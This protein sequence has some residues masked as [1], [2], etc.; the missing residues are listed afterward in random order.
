MTSRRAKHRL[1]QQLAQ[2]YARSADGRAKFAELLRQVREH[3]PGQAAPE[4]AAPQAIL[5]GDITRCVMDEGVAP[6][7]K[8]SFSAFIFDPRQRQFKDDE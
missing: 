3:V 6:P 1:R 5:Q 7:L 4:R 8:S 2:D